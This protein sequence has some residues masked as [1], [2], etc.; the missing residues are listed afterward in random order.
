MYIDNKNIKS[1]T[2]FAVTAV[3]MGFGILATL[4]KFIFYFCNPLKEHSRW[5][6]HHEIFSEN[7]KML[8]DKACPDCGGGMRAQAQFCPHCGYKAQG[9]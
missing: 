4:L 1:H 9:I 7:E 5:V 8:S 2:F 6:L 3:I